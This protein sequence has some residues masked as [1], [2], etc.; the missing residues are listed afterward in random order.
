V[1][2]ARGEIEL[3]GTVLVIKRIHVT[4]RGVHVGEDQR[5]AVDRV[6][7][8]HA[9]GCPVARS[10]KGAIEITT[11]LESTDAPLS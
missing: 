6:L 2:H 4:Y 8:V 3:D 7:G 11:S 1:G 9:D 10:L 5:A